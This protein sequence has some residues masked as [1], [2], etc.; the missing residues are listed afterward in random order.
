MFI[1][2]SQL[3]REDSSKNKTHIFCCELYLLLFILIIDPANIHLFKVNNRNIRKCE[4]RSKLTTFSSV[5]IVDF[6]RVNVCWAVVKN[7]SYLT[8]S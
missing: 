1:M 6:E 2:L 5:S 7:N 4:I 8:V 3:L